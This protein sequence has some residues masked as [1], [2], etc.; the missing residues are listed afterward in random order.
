MADFNF[1]PSKYE[2]TNDFEPIPAGEYE[3]VINTAGW[4]NTKDGTGRYLALEFELTRDYAGRRIFENL[5]LENRNE[6]AVQIAQGSLSAICRALGVSMLTDTNQLLN[7]PM[8]I[9]VS[10]QKD[11]RYGDKNR[12]RKYMPSLSVVPSTPDMEEINEEL[13]F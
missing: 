10:I 7:K 2:P 3:A 1:D 13:P 5:N 9:K 4:K 11:E 8:I 12:I 6:K